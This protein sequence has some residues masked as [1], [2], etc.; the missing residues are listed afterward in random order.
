MVIG[1]DFQAKESDK[2]FNPT[3]SGIIDTRQYAVLSEVPKDWPRRRAP[4]CIDPRSSQVIQEAPLLD[5]RYSHL[6]T[7]DVEATSSETITP[8][9]VQGVA[10]VSEGVGPVQSTTSSHSIYAGGDEL[11]DVLVQQLLDTRA[12]TYAD[13]LFPGPFS[14]D[15]LAP[16]STD[17]LDGADDSLGDDYSLYHDSYLASFSD[18]LD[19]D[20]LL[21]SPV[22]DR[23]SSVRYLDVSL[24][25][26]VEDIQ[27]LVVNDG[28]TDDTKPTF[29]GK[30]KPGSWPSNWATVDPRGKQYCMNAL[31]KGS[32]S[33]GCGR[34]HQCPVKT[35]TGVACNGNHLPDACPNK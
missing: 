4:F 11:H 30:G 16:V 25:E 27:G 17:I 35:A 1:V 28:V 3:T 20:N 8:P 34:S 31:L 5:T 2:I 13:S 9:P 22:A 23:R 12:P 24:T 19:Q 21:F 18:Q 15:A 14:P 32:C 26:G 6:A 10:P 33:G 7:N 29:S